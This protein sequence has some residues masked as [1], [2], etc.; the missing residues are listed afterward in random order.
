MIITYHKL[1][2]KYYTLRKVKVLF[3]HNKFKYQ[4]TAL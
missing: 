1:L 4:K 3:L 2:L